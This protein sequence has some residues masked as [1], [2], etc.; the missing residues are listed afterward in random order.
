[1]S[2]ALKTARELRRSDRIRGVVIALIVSSSI[3]NELVRFFNGCDNLYPLIGVSLGGIVAAAT[4]IL[5]RKCHDNMIKNEDKALEAT[6]ALLK[7]VK[8]ETQTYGLIYKFLHDMPI[9]II[10][11]LRETKGN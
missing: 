4:Q 7:L 6:I 2:R 11:R 5:E 10:R 8:A 1:M 3:A 9:P